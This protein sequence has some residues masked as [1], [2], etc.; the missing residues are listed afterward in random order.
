MPTRR[1]VLYVTLYRVPHS[2]AFQEL[3]CACASHS[4]LRSD[5]WLH[6]RLSYYQPNNRAYEPRRYTSTLYRVSHNPLTQHTL[7]MHQAMRTQITTQIP[8]GSPPAASTTMHPIHRGVQ[9][10]H[11]DT[12]IL[13]A[14]GRNITL[15][16][17]CPYATTPTLGT[18]SPCILGPTCVHRCVFSYADTSHGCLPYYLA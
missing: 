5:S 9:C 6:A 12:A 13:C 17:L 14:E 15:K 16:R 8:P 10:L 18:L 2:S 3:L 4:R 1:D 7:T 11:C